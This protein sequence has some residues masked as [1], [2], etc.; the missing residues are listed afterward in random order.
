MNEERTTVIN[1]ESNLHD[2]QNK[3]PRCG[4]TDISLNPSNGKLRCNFCRFEFEPET[5]AQKEPDISQIRGRIIGS[6]AADI[7]QDANNIITL[8]C[9]SC[10][11]EVVIDTEESAQARCHWCRNTLSI[12]H[13]IPNGAVP[14]TV[15]PFKISK[16]DSR[17]AIENFVGKRK[18]FAHPQFKREFKTDNIMGVYLPYMIVDSNSH[19]TLRGQGEKETRKW[20]EKNGDSQRTYYDADLFNVQRDFD[21]TV[22]GLTVESSRDKLDK[23]NSGRTN[24]IINSIMPF[25]TE[26]CV[27]WNANYLKG[28]SSEKRDINISE[29]EPVVE[30]QTKDIARTAANKTIKNYDRGV[31][32]DNENLC[33][34][35]ERWKLAYL[36]VWLYSYQQKKKNGSDLLHYVA[37]NARTKETMGSVPIHMPKLFLFSLLIELVCAAAAVLLRKEL[38]RANWP[39]ILLIIGLIFFG[40]IYSRYRNTSARHSYETETK[41]NVLNLM[42][43]DVFVES[44]HKLSESSMQGAN[45]NKI[46]GDSVY[47]SSSGSGKT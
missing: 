5:T 8:K 3:C 25:D 7:A 37:V 40:V 19:V 45:N 1:T 16:K 33:V 38:D 39:Y 34:K 47:R 18:F 32:W 14:D 23:S 46:T 36:P 21:M 44:R 30:A 10:G 2:G 13:Q 12:N 9:E 35:G 28:Y 41:T 24:N 29:L 20:T 27:S 22:E 26:N 31:R 17:T 43:N 6:G 4:A 42:S 11:A 15:L